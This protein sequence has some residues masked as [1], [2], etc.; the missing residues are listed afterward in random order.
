M[1][2]RTR[3]KMGLAFACWTLRV[4]PRATRHPHG[5]KPSTRLANRA[6]FCSVPL[7]RIHNRFAKQLRLTPS[8]T[9]YLGRRHSSG[10]CYCPQ[11]PGMAPFLSRDQSTHNYYQTLARQCRLLYIT[12]IPAN[13]VCIFWYVSTC[14]IC[15]YPWSAL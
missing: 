1:W 13:M 4:F 6:S 8:A 5:R 9:V 12:P 2:C 15:I 11:G 7:H 10:H 3:T 14:I